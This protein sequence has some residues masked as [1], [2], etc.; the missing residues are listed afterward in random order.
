[1]LT[2]ALLI[3]MCTGPDGYMKTG[4]VWHQHGV[5]RSEVIGIFATAAIE[6]FNAAIE[7]VNRDNGGLSKL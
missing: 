4:I 7:H 3:L 5:A 1:M 2:C 6:A